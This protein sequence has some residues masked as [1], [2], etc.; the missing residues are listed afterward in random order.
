LTW[1]SGEVVTSSGA[2]SGFA[3][4]VAMYYVYLLKS[5]INNDLYVGYSEDLRRRF[6]EHNEGK[7]HSTQAYRPWILVY[8]EAYKGKGDATKREYQL[9]KHAA[10]ED[11][12]GRLTSSLL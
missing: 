3:R 2:R 7:V 11:L 6:S 12:K 8:Y 4:R 10:K 9:K 5:T 1:R